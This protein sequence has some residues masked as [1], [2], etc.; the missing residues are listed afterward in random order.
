MSSPVPKESI[1]ISALLP[2]SWDMSQP[3]WPDDGSVRTH[4]PH[5]PAICRNLTPASE[6]FSITAY[7]PPMLRFDTAGHAIFAQIFG[8]SAFTQ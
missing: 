7:K 1:M 6:K 3:T 2:W 4:N 5:D 8:S